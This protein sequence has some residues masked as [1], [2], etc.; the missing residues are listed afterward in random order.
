MLVDAMGW[1][2]RQKLTGHQ[3]IRRAAFIPPHRVEAYFFRRMPA[4]LGFVY[5]LTAPV[6][7]ET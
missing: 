2:A 6:I 4:E 7:A 5:S 1:Q 3:C